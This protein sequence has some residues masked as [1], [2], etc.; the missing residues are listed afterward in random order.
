M[1]PTKMDNLISVKNAA[2]ILTDKPLLTSDLDDHSNVVEVENPQKEW[3][4]D[5]KEKIAI[6]DFG[7]QYGKVLFL[8]FFI[9]F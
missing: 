6:M 2:T 3:K 5:E 9:V 8:L 7:A 1:N 4:S